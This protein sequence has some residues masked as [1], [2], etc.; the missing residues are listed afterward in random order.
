MIK[1]GTFGHAIIFATIGL[2][3]ALLS[4]GQWISY[5]FS[6]S[7]IGWALTLARQSGFEDHEDI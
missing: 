3:I 4:D 7:I 2:W 6:G 1:I 5:F